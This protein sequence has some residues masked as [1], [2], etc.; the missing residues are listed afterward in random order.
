MN[1]A[2]WRQIEDLYDSAA[3]R[4]PEER[5]PFL[6]QACAGDAELRRE[7][8]SLLA[9]GDTPSAFLDSPAWE[10]QNTSALP[11]GTKL[12]PYEI[13][14]RV[15]TGGMGEVYRAQDTRLLRTVAIKT[16]RGQFSD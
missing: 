5:G 3:I 9:H 6:D 16:C 11:A 10:F 2:R 8:Q 7:V 13:I 15:G 1:P 14:G 12:G 4:T